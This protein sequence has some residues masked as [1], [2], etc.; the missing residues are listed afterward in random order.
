MPNIDTSGT[1]ADLN[2]KI[3]GILGLYGAPTFTRGENVL[4]LIKS[5]HRQVEKEYEAYKNAHRDMEKRK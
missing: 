5:D 4:R 1:V 3:G 2:A